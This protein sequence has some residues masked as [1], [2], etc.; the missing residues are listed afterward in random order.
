MNM[1]NL[2]LYLQ[3]F[4]EGAD[5]DTAQ[6]TGEKEAVAAPQ[7]TGEHTPS[8]A[9]ME[10]L[11]AEFAQLIKGKYRTAYNQRVQ[12]TLQKRLRDHKELTEKMASLTPVLEALESRCGVSAGDIPALQ[13]AVEA[14]PSRQDQV[15]RQQAVWAKQAAQA[16]NLYPGFDLGKELE[17]PVFRKL[18]QGDVPVQIAYEVLHRDQLFQGAMAH[19]AFTVERKLAN[20]LAA[21]G[22]RPG[23]S[24]MGNSAASPVRNDVSQ[25]S[26]KDRQDI[27]RRVRKGETIRF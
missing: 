14:M 20:N 15:T 8:A 26:R 19:T 16:Q 23:E 13:Q 27:I 5:S 17:N 11:D 22:S 3:L 7:A 10:D 24:A 6:F 9:G 12:E 25:M 21:M 4:A 18:L 2:E 1:K